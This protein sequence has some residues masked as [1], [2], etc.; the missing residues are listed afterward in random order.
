MAPLILVMPLVTFV[1]TI[2]IQC[3]VHAY[4]RTNDG[5]HTIASVGTTAEVWFLLFFHISY[6]S[7]DSG[8][9]CGNPFDTDTNLSYLTYTHIMSIGGLLVFLFIELF[10][11]E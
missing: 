5:H 1:F 8:V 9:I 11:I 6:F 3:Q 4:R 10:L 7:V 2:D